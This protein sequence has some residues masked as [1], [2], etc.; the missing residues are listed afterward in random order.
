MWLYHKERSPKDADGM[1]NSVDPTRV[2]SDLGLSVRKL[3]SST[4]ITMCVLFDSFLKAYLFPCSPVLKSFKIPNKSELNATKLLKFYCDEPPHNKN[5]KMACAP[6]EDSDQR[7]HL[8][9]L[10]CP[11]E[12]SFGP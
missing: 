5:N 8:P 10:R 4:G 2:K 3:R 12:E 6:S 7:G 9:S 11:R 1:A